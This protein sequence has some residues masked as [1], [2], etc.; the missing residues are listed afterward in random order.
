[1]PD[2][3]RVAIVT[4]SSRG[5]EAAVAERLASDGFAVAI[6]CSGASAQAAQLVKRI[7]GAGGRASSAQADVSDPAAVAGLF[8]KV[9]AQFGGVDVLVNNAGILKLGLIALAS[10]ET[11]DQTAA[12]NLKGGF[13][14]MREPARRLRDGDR[15][16]SFTSSVVGLYQP[17]YGLYAATKAAVKAMTRVLAKELGERRITVNAIAP[18]PVATELFLDGKP[19]ELIDRIA[20]MNPLGRLGA[21][22]GI[23]RAVAFLVGPDGGW[24]NGQ[25][26]RANGG[27]V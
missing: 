24:V 16:V 17:T 6:N 10:D 26:L 7:S 5:L 3:G 9:E 8:D 11:F 20:K 14:G 12:V 4:G 1:M 21:V 18:E 15:I 22:E 27:V 23:A 25:V 2:N 13:N 19:P